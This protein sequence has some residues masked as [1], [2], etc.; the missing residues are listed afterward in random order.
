MSDM[1]W[2][3]MSSRVNLC[4]SVTCLIKH[5]IGN[6]TQLGDNTILFN[7]SAEDFCGHT[8]KYRAYGEDVYPHHFDN[9]HNTK[10]GRSNKLRKESLK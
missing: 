6:R 9:I 8:I 2:K 10:C 1:L 5:I 3:T 7:P 4:K